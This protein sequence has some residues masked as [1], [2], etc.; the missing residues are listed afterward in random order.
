MEV[1][2]VRIPHGCT[3]HVRS[4]RCLVQVGQLGDRHL[5]YI[6]VDRDP[7]LVVRRAE[8]ARRIARTADEANGQRQSIGADRRVVDAGAISGRRRRRVRRPE[9]LMERLRCRSG[10]ERNWSPLTAEQQ[11]K[12][13]DQRDGRQDLPQPVHVGQRDVTRGCRRLR[14]RGVIRA[15]PPWSSG[16][17]RAGGTCRGAGRRR[18]PAPCRCRATSGRTRRTGRPPSGR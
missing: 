1:E 8:I 17:R 12:K 11:R 3:R 7:R 4:R 6:A 18:P 15:R 2:R 13:R 16:R 9:G 10:E 5:Q 14:R